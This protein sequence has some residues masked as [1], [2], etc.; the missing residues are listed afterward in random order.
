MASKATGDPKAVRFSTEILFDP[1][2]GDQ[3]V[4]TWFGTKGAIY[5]LLAAFKGAGG[6]KVALTHDGPKYKLVATFSALGLRDG[7]V[8]I[9]VDKWQLQ[10]EWVQV[11]IRHSPK[12]LALPIAG[13][14]TAIAKAYLAAQTAVKTQTPAALTSLATVFYNLL[15]HGADSYEIKR[16]VLTRVRTVSPFYAQQIMVSAVEQVYSTATL[17]SGFAIPPAISSR[18]PV[19][20][21]GL[22]TDCVWAWKERKQS[23]EFTLALNKVEEQNDWVFSLWN[24]NLYDVV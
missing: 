1:Q 7:S 3:L 9:P 8:E 18:L 12:I 2:S 23:S 21:S 20:P 11:D 5:G 15:A 19:N 16:P 10:T 22:I 24:T 13:S 4:E 6:V 17:I 14:P